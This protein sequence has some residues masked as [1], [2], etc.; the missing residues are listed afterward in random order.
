MLARSFDLNT[1][2][3]RPSFYRGTTQQLARRLL[4]ALLVHE[5][6]DGLCVGRIVETEAYLHQGDAASHS[7]RGETPRNRAMF[8][9]AGHAYL[10]RIY[11]I[12]VCFNVVSMA[13]GQGAAVLVRALEPLAGLELMAQ[14]RAA[15]GAPDACA[16]ARALCSGP[17]KLVQALGL[18]LEQDGHPLGE[19]ALRVHEPEAGFRPG[20]VRAVPRIGISSATSKRLHYYP[21]S[22]P[23]V[24]RPHSGG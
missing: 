6:P 17:G 18:D 15:A 12:H 11:G 2:V 24:S 20:V 22:C 21:R 8:L 14:R 16:D 7:Y 1:P 4:G 10:Y 23:W 3:C 5:S 13:A 19:G 9:P